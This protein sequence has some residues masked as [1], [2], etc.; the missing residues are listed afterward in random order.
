MTDSEPVAG[1]RVATI[2]V[3][4][5]MFSDLKPAGRPV[6]I[7]QAA[8]LVPEL[9]RNHKDKSEPVSDTH[10]G[11]GAV[12]RAIVPHQADLVEIR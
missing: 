7:V 11:F 2:F 9:S 6:P 3:C 8:G 5:I 10:R 1:P 4:G 12:R